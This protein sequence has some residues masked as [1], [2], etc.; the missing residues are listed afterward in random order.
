[1]KKLFFAASLIICS[2]LVIPAVKADPA[3]TEYEIPV[4]IIEPAQTEV[5]VAEPIPEPVFEPEVTQETAASPEATAA[6]E[7]TATP[8]PT[9]VPTP[10]VTPEPVI[11][12]YEGD[13]EELEPDTT[14]EPEVEVEELQDLDERSHGKKVTALQERL[15]EKGY[16][17]QEADGLYGSMTKAA[18]ALLQYQSGLKITG[19]ADIALQ[20]YLYSDSCPNSM[21]YPAL[22]F[23]DISSDPEKARGETVRFEGRVL[24]AIIGDEIEMRVATR[25]AYEDVVYITC[26]VPETKTEEDTEEP[27]APFV[28][29]DRLLV[30]GT[31]EGTYSYKSTSGKTVTLPFIKAEPVIK[32]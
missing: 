9:A 22:V 13:D 6:P 12:M 31:V 7:S 1:M 4:M 5:P 2:C 25:G 32:K 17:L 19:T 21:P 20:E 28:E 23:D 18:V 30:F 3:A 29:G 11:I 24:Q 27:A 14:E 8:E 26:A 15:I 16:L 10:A